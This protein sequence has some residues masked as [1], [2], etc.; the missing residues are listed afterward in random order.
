[1]NN[2]SPG[3]DGI[4]CEF[5][6]CFIEEVTLVLNKVFNY[7]VQSR[8]PPKSWS[9]AIISVLHKDPTLCVGSQTCKLTMIK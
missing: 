7:A 6:K 8:D 5:Y 1:M 3:T 2:K 9:R 4:P